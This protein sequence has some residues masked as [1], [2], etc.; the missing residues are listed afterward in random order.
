MALNQNIQTPLTLYSGSLSA[1]TVA[2]GATQGQLMTI[3]SSSLPAYQ[4]AFWNYKI[5]TETTYITASAQT[6]IS[7]LSVNLT[8]SGYFLIIGYYGIGGSSTTNPPRLGNSQTSLTDSSI[9]TELPDTLTSVQHNY[10]GTT[11]PPITTWPSNNINNFYL[12]KHIFIGKP[13]ATSATFI[14]SIAVSSS[15]ANITASMGP[16]VIFYKKII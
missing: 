11:G 14:P 5:K 16:S 13:N 12:A 2:S 6:T 1:H 3:I 4:S 7:E 15:A 9:I 10:E 8:G